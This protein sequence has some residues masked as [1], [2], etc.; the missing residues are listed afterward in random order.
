MLKVEA[1]AWVLSVWV[2]VC[3]DVVAVSVADVAAPGGGVT[4]QVAAALLPAGIVAGAGSALAVQ[5]AGS[6]RLLV[7]LLAVAPP[8][9][10]SVSVTV[11]AI[12]GGITCGAL[13]VD[14]TYAAAGS[15]TVSSA[16]LA[17]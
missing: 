2:A 14:V 13:S 9:D 4:D 1:D 17:G 15:G 5:P 8:A 7:T 12:P 11:E 16:M 3:Q 6:A 10:R